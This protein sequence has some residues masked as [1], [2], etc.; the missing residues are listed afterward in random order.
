LEGKEKIVCTQK[1]ANIMHSS[2]EAKWETY[3]AKWETYEAK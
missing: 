2:C 1:E 3:E